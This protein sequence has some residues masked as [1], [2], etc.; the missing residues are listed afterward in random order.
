MTW[1]LFIRYNGH[2]LINPF[3]WLLN[4]RS[5]NSIYS[6][7]VKYSDIRTETK[8]SWSQQLSQEEFY[9]W[10]ISIF[11]NL[12]WPFL[13]DNNSTKYLIIA[14]VSMFKWIQKL[15]RL[16]PRNEGMKVLLCWLGASL[17][18][19]LPLFWV[20]NFLAHVL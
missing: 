17:D 1:K 8:L 9:T 6:S 12:F 11:D 2:S 15:G 4:K 13:T 18:A 7:P 20:D 10:K 19:F 5:Q 3:L 16:R 14:H